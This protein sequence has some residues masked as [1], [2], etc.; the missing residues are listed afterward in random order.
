MYSTLSPHRK[1]GTD[2]D[3]K[4]TITMHSVTYSLGAIREITP[5]PGEQLHKVKR[6]RL[7]NRLNKMWA[8]KGTP[9]TTTL[10]STVSHMSYQN[11]LKGHVLKVW[12][13]G[14]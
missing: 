6:K 10:L 7:G 1:K 4:D 3:M 13:L 11:R 9:F 5:I 14:S 8:S 12:F 2:R